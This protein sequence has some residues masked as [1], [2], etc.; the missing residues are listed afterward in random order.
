MERSRGKKSRECTKKSEDFNSAPLYHFERIKKCQV[1][2][3]CF[4]TREVWRKEKER[5]KSVAK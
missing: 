4:A 5:L 2:R 3:V 1:T